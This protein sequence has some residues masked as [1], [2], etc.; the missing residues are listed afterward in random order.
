MSKWSRHKGCL[1]RSGNVATAFAMGMGGTTAVVVVLG[2]LIGMVV[3]GGEK[4]TPEEQVSNQVDS[5][6]DS[7]QAGK[8]ADTYRNETTN[9]FREAVKINDYLEIGEKITGRF[10]A[11][12]SKE[13]TKF[14]CQQLPAGGLQAL[15]IY[16]GTFE[17][18]HGKI[19]TLFRKVDKKWLLENFMVEPPDGK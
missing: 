4:G 17:K 10:G 13:S 15:A 2:L 18:G 7:L 8:F 14:E 3:G 5:L 19:T 12:Q 16:D 6:F 9:R 11:L 1:A